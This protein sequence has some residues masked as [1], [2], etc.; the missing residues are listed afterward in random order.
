MSQAGV[1]MVIDR[2]L[3]DRVFRIRFGLNPRAAIVGLYLG[4]FDLTHE[5]VEM[6][7]RTD[8]GVWSPRDAVRWA[9]GH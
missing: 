2:L 6:L 5:E 1:G 4:G 7:C 8:A 3:T 9:A